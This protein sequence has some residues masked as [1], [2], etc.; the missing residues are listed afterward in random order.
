MSRPASTSVMRLS[1][2]SPI[3]IASA[4]I[5]RR[6]SSPFKSHSLFRLVPKSIASLPK[7]RTA[8]LSAQII[9]GNTTQFAPSAPCRL[10]RKNSPKA[11]AENC[12]LTVAGN[13]SNGQSISFL[14]PTRQTPLFR[15]CLQ[16]GM[17]AI[18]PSTLMSTGK[19]E[20]PRGCFLPSV[21]Y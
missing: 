18:K 3:A 5:F 15:W 9:S 14:L 4:R 21:G 13:L 1:K 7:M 6:R 11:R 17:R 20:E 16:Q 10:T 12:S 2:T 19:Y 8:K